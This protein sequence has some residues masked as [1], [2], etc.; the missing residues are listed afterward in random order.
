LKGT[1]WHHR[2]FL[3]FWIGDTVT[4]FTGQ[5]TVLVL[6]TL[7]ILTLNVT[8]FELGILNALGFI[9]FPT[10]GLFAGVLLDRVRRKP[11][12]IAVNVV[13]LVT[14]ATIPVTFV[15]GV[16]GLY[17]LYAVALIMGI[18]QL[19]FDVG[20]QSYLPS[21]VDKEEVV[22]GN[23]K[24]QV[25]ASAAQVAGPSVASALMG[26]VGTAQ[27]VAVDVLGFFT[28]V[29]MLASIKKPEPKPKCVSTDGQG[30][31]FA[32]MEEGIRIITGNKL[33]WTQAGC[34]ATTNLGMNMFNVAILLY[35]YRT[36]GISKDIIGIAFSIGAFGFV[37]GVLLCSR[38][39]KRLGV[40]K[41]TS[42]SVLANFGML[43][44]LFASPGDFGVLVIGIALFVNYL[45]VPVYNINMVSLRQIITPNRLQGRMN[46]TMRTLVWGTIPIGA[47]LGGILCTAV[48]LV[49]TLLIGA[50]V[51]GLAA[52]WVIFGPI[53]KL[54]KQPEPAEE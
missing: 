43:L 50:V 48:G 33:L 47:F 27:S 14:L 36:L 18:C 6:P 53:Y 5:V 37:L 49:P 52:L 21:L 34:T 45:G 31:F 2:D 19:F 9:A 15:L 44:V 8:D 24:L 12:M 28:S 16:L 42:L 4:Q 40:G 7:A 41:A 25:S 35:A 32:E 11:V 51:A 30:H 20:Y 46:A 17:Q 13:R 23:E 22:E 29:L 1:L 38:L 26:L 10:L 3:R 39:T 54:Q